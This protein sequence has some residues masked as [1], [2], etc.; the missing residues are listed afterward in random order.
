MAA[1]QNNDQYIGQLLVRDGII[2][3]T[4]LDRGLAE[5]RKNREFLCSNLVRLGLASEEK[6]FSILSLQIGVPFLS[7]KEVKTDP[8]VLSLIPGTFALA[9]KCVPLKTVEDVFYVAM[10]DP[11]NGRAVDEIKSYVGFEKVKVFLAG[12]AD[13]R[14]T[15]QKYYG[16]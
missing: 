10:S 8:S 11:L 5:Q 16:I 2:T 15:I 13:I 3:S 12:D 14:S 4:E 7:L 9:C 1:I 6:I